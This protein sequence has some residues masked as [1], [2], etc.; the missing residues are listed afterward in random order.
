MPHHVAWTVRRSLLA[1]GLGLLG[2]TGVARPAR[3]CSPPPC[4]A[5]RFIPDEGT[6]VPANVPALLYAPWQRAGGAA[7]SASG[8]RL[9]DEGGAA[10]AVTATPTANPSVFLVAPTAPLVAGR[11]YRVEYPQTCTTEF[12]MQV[13]SVAQSFTA[14]AASA[15]PATVGRVAAVRHRI[16]RRTVWSARSPGLCSATSE[17]TA[18]VARI[19][20]E[21]SPELRALLATTRVGLRRDTAHIAIL[22]QPRLAAAEP[23]VLEAFTT[24]VTDDA[25]ADKGLPAGA[26][27]LSIWAETLGTSSQPA[28]LPV[29]VMLDCAS[30]RDGGGVPDAGVGDAGAVADAIAPDTRSADAPASD[31]GS[32][33]GGPGPDSAPAPDARTPPPVDGG[34]DAA[35]RDAAGPGPASR[36]GCDCALASGVPPGAPGLALAAGPILAAGVWRRRRA[37]RS[38]EEA[39][40]RP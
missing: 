7:P 33:D 31:A 4:S 3:A 25:L 30:A 18:A 8:L 9:L 38:R 5:A 16:E 2:T 39:A 17:V 32:N 14:A 19:E 12:P 40:P 20:V 10:V 15:L 35:Q 26:H 22:E 21:P 24:C 1:V 13:G 6:T 11:R 29:D 28:P 36:S 27:R 34:G 23:L 37:R